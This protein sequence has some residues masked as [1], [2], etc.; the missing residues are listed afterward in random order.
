MERE[1]RDEELLLLWEFSQLL[2][3]DRKKVI[4]YV[5]SIID[6]EAEYNSWVNMIR[7]KVYEV[8]VNKTII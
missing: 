5:K 7:G 8:K 6:I 1:L 3:E 2:E 4:E